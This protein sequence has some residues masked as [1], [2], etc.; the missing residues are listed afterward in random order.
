MRRED[1][2]SRHIRIVPYG[3]YANVAFQYML[4]K[5][6]K[7]SVPGSSIIGAYLPYWGIDTRRVDIPMM[8]YSMEV[9]SHVFPLQHVIQTLSTAEDAE[10]VLRCL[11]TRMAYYQDHRDLFFSDFHAEEAKGLEGYGSDSLVISIRLGEI[12]REKHQFYAPLPISWYN[13]LIRET[14]L[15]PV[16]YGQIG[17]DV[18]STAL[19]AQFPDAEFVP[20]RGAL[21]DFHV[22]RNSKNVALS[23]STFAWLATWISEKTENIFLPIY[24][25][26]NPDGRP[27]VDMLPVNDGRYHF[28]QFAETR[29]GTTAAEVADLLTRENGGMKIDPAEIL[30]RYPGTGTDGTSLKTKPTVLAASKE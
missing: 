11:S 13:S 21:A 9:R 27:D 30:A 8:A 28:Y 6:I 10:V 14:G 2:V 5:V 1:S 25:M 16:F 26:F 15:K 22:L 20:S 17:D 4:A 12:L 24:M 29:W 23:V 3:S 19:K 18:Y 7:A